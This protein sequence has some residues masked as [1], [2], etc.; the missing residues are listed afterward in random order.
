M[1]MEVKKKNAW[2][3]VKHLIAL[4]W[5][6]GNY[7]REILAL[8]GVALMLNLLNLIT[9]WMFREYHV[10]DFVLME[11]YGIIENI[12]LIIYTARILFR[13]SS[14]LSQDSVSMYP[15]TVKTRYISR[16]LSDCLVLVAFVVAETLLNL[17]VT[18]GYMLMSKMTGKFGDVLIIGN[19]GWAMV[20]TLFVI[21][22]IYSVILFLQTLYDRF[23]SVKF[24]IG[25]LV[26]VGILLSEIYTPFHVLNACFGFIDYVVCS[27]G[28]ALASVLL[29]T[30]VVS[31]VCFL[32]SYLI[33][34]GIRSWKKEQAYSGS[35]CICFIVL[36]VIIVIMGFCRFDT[37]GERV[38]SQGGTLE[39]QVKAGAYLIEDSVEQLVID[40]K[41][42]KK[43]N[44]SLEKI[45]DN[46]SVQWISLED[47]KKAGI[48]DE[49]ASL[50]PNEIGI[51]TVVKNCE[52]QGTSL[53]KGFLNAK[54]TVEDGS[55]R[56][57]EPLRVV[58]KNNYLSVFHDVFL[59]DEEQG[60]LDD[61]QGY[62]LS[63]FLGYFIFYNEEDIAESDVPMSLSA[64]SALDEFMWEIDE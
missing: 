30:S 6:N 10:E 12:F 5:R 7:V 52:V 25:V 2:S 38:I 21:L 56:V 48:V 39:E 26:A 15:G 42:M 16:I 43:L 34:C 13:M 57:K 55:Y 44:S 4:R 45:E 14:V 53:T 33:V 60:N 22:A 1:S 31:V 28:S 36:F 29:I 18:G 51:R 9:T 41:V 19:M 3:N 64:G 17:L 27:V 40:Q 54:L 23:G 46:Y 11:K 24:S 58:L 59:S 49:T 37:G 63:R 35:L 20:L 32:L 47:A 8:C 62:N 50:Q 61:V